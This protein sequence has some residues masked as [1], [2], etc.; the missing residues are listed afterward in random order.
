[1]IRVEQAL[2]IILHSVT[3]VETGRINLCDSL[4]RALMEDCYAKNNNIPPFDPLLAYAPACGIQYWHR[5]LSD[6][7][8]DTIGINKGKN[9]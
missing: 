3:S 6:K 4:M 8:S 1:M 5:E 7:H 2:E 9:I